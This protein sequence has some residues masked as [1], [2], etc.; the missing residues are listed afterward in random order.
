MHKKMAGKSRD[1]SRHSSPICA[2]LLKFGCVTRA[3]RNVVRPIGTFTGRSCM[4]RSAIL[5]QGPCFTTS[6]ILSNLSHFNYRSPCRGNRLS[7]ES[8]DHRRWA[9][10]AVFFLR[11]TPST[12][13][14]DR[15]QNLQRVHTP[16]LTR[17]FPPFESSWADGAS[18][19]RQTTGDASPCG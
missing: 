4:G 5:P 2:Q 6:V 9:A 8:I 15:G 7:I 1:S 10:F 11:P 16:N 17:L 12:A 18:R 3:S 14:E 19:S 13:S